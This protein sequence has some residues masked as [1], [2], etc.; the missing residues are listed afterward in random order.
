MKSFAL[1]TLVLAAF[2]AVAPT[3]RAASA[4]ITDTTVLNFALTLEHL[5]N[6]FYAGALKKFSAKDFTNAGL[7]AYARGQGVLSAGVLAAVRGRDGVLSALIMGVV[8]LLS[9]SLSRGE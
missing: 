3:K 4:A 8:V 6:A 9:R 2:G 7:S 1:A 5:E